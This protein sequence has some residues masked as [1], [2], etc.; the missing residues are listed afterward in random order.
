METRFAFGENWSRFLRVLDDGRIA[1]AERSLSAALGGLRGRTFLDAGSGSGLFSLAARRLGARVRSF[2]YDPESVA[3]T[4]ELKRRCFPEDPEWTVEQGSVLDA[5]WLSSLGTFDVVY[6]W[7][8]LHHTGDLWAAL[9]NA[10]AAVAPQGL[11]YVSIYNDQGWP[12]RAWTHVK[13]LYNGA[14]PLRPLLLAASLLQQWGPI[15][16]ADLVRLRPFDVWR[17]YGKNRGMSPWHDLVDWVG[18]YPFQVAKP[19]EVFDFCAARGF[20]LQKLRTVAGSLGCNEFVFA[21]R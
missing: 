20:S 12:S 19:E 10:C 11:L 5:A 4:A 6:S 2:D 1:E 8:V 14:P 16:V 13:K 21:R 18:G 3:C 17:R 9:G 7:G 15:S